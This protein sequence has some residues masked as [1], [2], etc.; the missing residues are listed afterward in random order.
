MKSGVVRVEGSGRLGKNWAHQRRL[1]VFIYRVHLAQESRPARCSGSV[2]GHI[3]SMSQRQV[4][5]S[6]QEWILIEVGSLAS[7]A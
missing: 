5:S 6:P 2:H 1:F 3:L 4:S 7:K